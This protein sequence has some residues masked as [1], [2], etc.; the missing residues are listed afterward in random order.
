VS[1]VLIRQA[2]TREGGRRE[3]HDT[4]LSESE[5]TIGSGGTSLIQLSGAGIAAAHAILRP[6][7][8]TAKLQVLKGQVARVNGEPVRRRKRVA[9]GDRIEIASHVLQILPAPAGFDL[10]VLVEP[11]ATPAAAAV[12]SRFTT[13][14][15]QTWLSKRQFAW[16]LCAGVLLFFLVLPLLLSGRDA[17]PPAD[18]FVENAAKPD[19]A[20]GS[21]PGASP[22]RTV[23]L[24]R[25]LTD[26]I[27]SSGDLHAGHEVATNG[28]CAACHVQPFVRVQDRACLSC[29]ESAGDHALAQ[30]VAAIGETADRCGKCHREHNEPSTLMQMSVASCANCHARDEGIDR[31]DDPVTAASGFAKGA[32]PPF[33]VTLPLLSRESGNTW[34][35]QTLALEG[36]TE[37]SNLIFPHDVH[38]DRERVREPGT[39]QP[40]GCSSCHQLAADGEHFRPVDMKSRCERCHELKFQ[41]EAPRLPHGDAGQAYATIASYFLAQ[42]DS[43]LARPASEFRWRRIPDRPPRG[44]LGCVGPARQCA[45]QNAMEEQFLRTGCASCHQVNTRQAAELADR[46]QVVPVRLISDLFPEERFSHKSHLIVDTLA[47]DRA[48]DYCHAAKQSP[49]SADV[50]APSVETCFECHADETR[51]SRVTLYCADCHAY[52]PRQRQQEPE[53]QPELSASL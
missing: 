1:A 18:E 35:F 33:E 21:P 36:A 20:P 16:G 6:G 53:S 28:D 22:V 10:A 40:L 3:Y 38:L 24:P 15:G 12:E 45:I 26:H 34:G 52:H 17:S 5:I 51:A 31:K 2:V 48:C 13:T 7:R 25:T 46:Y 29:H 19:V 44:G 23:S 30:A 27:W 37:S 11:S 9:A 32:H 39:E 42:P 4:E 41:K 50:L 47:G 43:A 8:G 14:L 49:T